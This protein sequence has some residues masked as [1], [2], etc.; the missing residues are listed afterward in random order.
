MPNIWTAPRTWNTGEIV[1]ASLMN[2]H[3]RDNLEHL[4]AKADAPLNTNPNLTTSSYTTS[5][6]TFGDVDTT[7]FSLSLTLGGVAPVLIGFSGVWKHSTALAECCL[8]VA[9]DGV[10]IGNTTYGLAYM[11]APAA[12]AYQ[13]FSFVQTRFIAAG[14]HTFKLQWRTSAATLSMGSIAPTS[15]FVVELI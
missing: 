1:T 14:A 6:G 2:Q 8:D 12:N 13:P 5:S 3:L 15:F 11:Q 9:L 10:R 7:N 4:K